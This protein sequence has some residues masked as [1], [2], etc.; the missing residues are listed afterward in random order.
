V[1]KVIMEILLATAVDFAEVL[2]QGHVSTV[3]NDTGLNLF[4]SARPM[5]DVVAINANDFDSQKE[6]CPYGLFLPI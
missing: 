4:Y 2:S 3:L 5:M 6:R 1:E